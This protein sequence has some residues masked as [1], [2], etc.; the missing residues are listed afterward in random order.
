VQQVTVVSDRL[1]VVSYLVTAFGMILPCLFTG[2]GELALIG[3]FAM[4][5]WGIAGALV[6]RNA[7]SG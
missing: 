5:P 2:A 4:I 7:P 6:M 1:T 3:F